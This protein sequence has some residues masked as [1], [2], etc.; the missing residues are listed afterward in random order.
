M[1]KWQSLRLNCKRINIVLKHFTKRFTNEYLSLLHEC[2]TYRTGKTD[3]DCQ[4]YIGDIVLLRE[5]F[6]PKMKWHK[7]RV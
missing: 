3:E 7:G 5:D 4:L 6:F 1:A 2:Y